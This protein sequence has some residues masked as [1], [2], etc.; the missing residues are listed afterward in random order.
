M[1]D[2]LTLMPFIN[3]KVGRGVYMVGIRCFNILNIILLL[4]TPGITQ[5]IILHTDDQPTDHPSDLVVGRWGS[6]ASC[7]V[8]GPNYIVTARHQ[9]GGVGSIVTIDGVEYQVAEVITKDDNDLRVARLETSQGQP[10]NLDAYVGIF[11]SQG[12]EF[13][14]KIVVGGY[15]KYRGSELT[16]DDGTVYGYSWTGSDNKTLRW[17]A[18]LLD[19]GYATLVTSSYS[20]LV[21]IA[22]FD[23]PAAASAVPCEGTIAEY[24]S[25]GGWFVKD[26]DG[27]WFLVAVSAYVTRLASWF[28]IPITTEKV[29]PDR[30][31]GIQVSAYSSWI[32]ANI[33]TCKF[34]PGDANEDGVVDVFDLSIL[35]ANYGGSGMTWENG[36]FNNDGV[37]DALDLSIMAANYV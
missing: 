34:P 7:V 18:N 2:Y 24:D 25:G 10:A 15:G 6:N 5:G 1:R 16:T 28:D 13:Y 4:L 36:D 29:D 11:T 30:M 26:S 35:A 23:G 19:R 17:G 14:E 22:D 31:Y 27:N 20:S 37:V 21:L 33:K 32:L 9:G 12:D 3:K 8:V